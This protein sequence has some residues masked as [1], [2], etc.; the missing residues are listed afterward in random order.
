MQLDCNNIRDTKTYKNTPVACGDLRN[1]SCNWHA[2][3]GY[4]MGSK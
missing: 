4:F 3:I 2:K 1:W